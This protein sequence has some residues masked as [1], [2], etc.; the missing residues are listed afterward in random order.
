MLLQLHNLLKPYRDLQP[1]QITINP[2]T[3]EAVSLLLA[4]QSMPIQANQ[5]AKINHLC[6]DLQIPLCID[7]AR[8]LL[9][10]NTSLDCALATLN[11]QSQHQNKTSDLACKA[12]ADWQHYESSK[13]QL[14]SLRSTLE[15]KQADYHRVIA[16][17]PAI[18]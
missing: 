18:M 5:L 16:N 4:G 11:Q 13:S 3:A 8:S 12:Y 1:S 6:G 17:R 15:K 14:P 9:T 2:Q 10:H 7:S